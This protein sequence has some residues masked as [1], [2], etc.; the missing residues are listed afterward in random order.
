M[1]VPDAYAGTKTVVRDLAA[2]A[3]DIVNRES[4]AGGAPAT[5]TAQ[6]PRMSPDGTHVAFLYNGAGLGHPAPGVNQAFVRDLAGRTTTLVS[7]RSGAAGAGGTVGVTLGGLSDRGA[8]VAFTTPEA[9]VGEQTDAVGAYLRVRDADFGNVG[10]SSVPVWDVP[11]P[12][13]DGGAPAPAPA[14]APAQKPSAGTPRGAV[15]SV[16]DRVAP[17]LTARLVRRR[18]RSRVK[19]ALTFRTSEAATLTITV[20]RAGRRP[21]TVTRRVKAGSGRVTLGRRARG[22][23]RVTVVATDAAGNRSK[24]VTTTLVVTRG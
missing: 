23:Y 3:I 24:A 11:E 18:V 12:T 16:A 7:R 17:T 14:P 21:A 6:T 10:E 15:T 22:R 4:G 8:C 5:G 2:N 9:L 1:N 19:P 13:G 20:R